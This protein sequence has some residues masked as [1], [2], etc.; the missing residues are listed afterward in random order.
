MVV[1]E[2]AKK[3]FIQHVGAFSSGTSPI[4]LQRKAARAP[5]SAPQRPRVVRSRRRAPSWTLREGRADG[6]L[7]WCGRQVVSVSMAWLLRL[8]L[9]SPKPQLEPRAP[10]SG[11]RS[12]QR[13][14]PPPS[15]PDLRAAAPT[16]SPAPPCELPLCSHTLCGPVIWPAVWPGPG[17]PPTNPAAEDLPGGRRHGFAA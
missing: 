10:R 8:E 13:P 14:P 4:V 16:A 7:L 2:C 1:A 6:C 12:S 3:S 17:A 5:A 15:A 9:L 11:A